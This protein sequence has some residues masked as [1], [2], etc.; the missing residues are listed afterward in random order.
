MPLGLV[1]V[2]WENNCEQHRKV[3]NLSETSSRLGATLAA[4]KCM[5]WQY[6]WLGGPKLSSPLFPD[7]VDIELLIFT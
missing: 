4:P 6:S 5:A 3:T 7:V 1:L 2:W